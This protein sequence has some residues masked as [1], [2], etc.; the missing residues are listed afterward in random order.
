MRNLIC[1]LVLSAALAA[2]RSSAA[3]IGASENLLGPT[4]TT[5]YNGDI[6]NGFSVVE[7]V[8]YDGASGPWQKALTN[9]DQHSIASGQQVLID[10]QLTNAGPAAWTD[11]HEEILPTPNGSPFP[12]FLFTAGSLQVDRNGAALVEG[13]DYTLVATTVDGGI[14]VTLGGDWVALSIFFNPGAN[15][16]SGDT[17][18]IR[19]NIF[20]VFGDSDLWD[21]G[22]SAWWPNTRPFPSQRRLVWHVLAVLY[23]AC[24][25]SIA[26]VADMAGSA[27]PNCR[28]TLRQ[29][30]SSTGFSGVV[31]DCGNL[32]SGNTT[33]ME[34][35]PQLAGRSCVAVT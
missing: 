25:G 9:S 27:E 33:L 2:T 3:V 1:L 10:E 15:I 4:T 30:R 23:S 18:R 12:D 31:I 21:V 8:T 28:N 6:N 14:G 7:T 19:K 26:A 13:A 32:R 35:G 11:W 29:E 24:C 34:R 5:T 16:Q 20:E 17:L 22:E